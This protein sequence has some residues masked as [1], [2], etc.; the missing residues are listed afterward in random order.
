MASQPCARRN[1]S[2]SGRSTPSATARMPWRRQMSSILSTMTR[3]EHAREALPQEGAV[4]LDDVDVEPAQLPQRGLAG[5]EVVHRH[6]EALGAQV[7]DER[8]H[9]FRLGDERRLRQLH[10]DA[11]RREAAAVEDFAKRARAA[12]RVGV[13]A[14]EVDRHG[15]AEAAGGGAALLRAADAIEH[16][17]V[18]RQQQPAVFKQLDEVVR[19]GDRPVGV[20]PAHER[21]RA[22]DARAVGGKLRLIIRHE[23][24]LRQP[25]LHIADQPR[26][27]GLAHV[28]GAVVERVEPVEPSLDRA[29]GQRRA[30]AHLA[31]GQAEVVHGVD[32]EAQEQAD[33]LKRRRERLRLR[34]DAGKTRPPARRTA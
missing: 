5:A 7:V 22:D 31:D 12:G 20:L 24:F 17:P 23:F 18:Q 4:E 14:R 2:C 30:V 32:A 6:E 11:L 9:A 15:R 33:L 29:L 3:P 16:I 26:L 34:A 25:G 28:L 1:S 21:L 10:A 27:R 19:R 8:R 13:Q